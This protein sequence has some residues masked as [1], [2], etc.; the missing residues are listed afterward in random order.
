MGP[1]LAY[2]NYLNRAKVRVL[3]QKLGPFKSMVF[4]TVTPTGSDVYDAT[5]AHGRTRLYIT[6]LA[7]SP[8]GKVVG[9]YFSALP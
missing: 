3:M 7:F 6:A 9:T 4:E 2:A 5:F 1:I 8:D